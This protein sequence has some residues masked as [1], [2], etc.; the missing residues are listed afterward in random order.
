MLS[1]GGVR[2]QT[3]AAET[4][5][6]INNKELFDKIVSLILR[7]ASNRRNDAGYGG[8]MDDGGASNLEDQ[9]KFFQYGLACKFPPE[10]EGYKK[11]LDPDYAQYLILKKRFGDG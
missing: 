5:D 4:T 8:R 3:L 10:W 9:A 1:A 7:D 2:F 11:L 6:M